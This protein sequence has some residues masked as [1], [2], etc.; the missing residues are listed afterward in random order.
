MALDLDPLD[1]REAATANLQRGHLVTFEI[2]AQLAVGRQVDEPRDLHQ[3]L[4][5]ALIE[6]RRL[7]GPVHEGQGLVD[8]VH[9]ASELGVDLV[10][11]PRQVLLRQLQRHAQLALRV[12]HLQRLLDER[13]A[14]ADRAAVLL[15]ELL[16]LDQHPLAH[17][18]LA[19]VV[20]DGGVLDLLQPLLL[21]FSAANG[22]SQIPST[23][24]AR[25]SDRVATRR[26]WPEVVGSRDSM[27]VTEA[28][29]N[30]SN[31]LRISS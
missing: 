1:V 27:A 6:D 18:D 8:L 4:E 26:E 31:S 20:Q 3:P 10:E 2:G 21:N 12:L 14:Q 15:V 9:P 5:A 16:R 11:A 17:A 28:S 24:L 7:V 30:P 23:F 19:E 22:P 29:T 13:E 25:S